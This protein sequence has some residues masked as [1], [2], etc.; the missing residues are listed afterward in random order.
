MLYLNDRFTK[1]SDNLP[2]NRSDLD[3]NAY[4]LR[5]P[6]KKRGYMRWWHSFTGVC[7]DSGE[8]R[9]FFIEYFIINPALGGDQP[10]LGQHPYYKKRGMKPSYVMIKAGV[11]PKAAGETSSFEETAD[12]SHEGKQL[13][14][15]YPI[16]SLK[17]AYNPLYMR[18][19]DCLFSERT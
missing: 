10:V 13:H 4:M 11:Y 16:S 14:A 12:S 17:V 1:E 5:G 3:R 6:L 19:E 7:K 8:A 2:M 18:I 9:T 15:F